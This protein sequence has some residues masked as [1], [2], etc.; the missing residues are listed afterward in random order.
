M[1]AQN[2]YDGDDATV[3]FIRGVGAECPERGTRS[4]WQVIQGS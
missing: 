1:I 2:P 3:P 4:R